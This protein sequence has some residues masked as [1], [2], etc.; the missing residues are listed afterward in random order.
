MLL[1]HTKIAQSSA[2]INNNNAADGANEQQ[3]NADPDPNTQIQIPRS[4]H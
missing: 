2:S 3:E 4:I 1:G